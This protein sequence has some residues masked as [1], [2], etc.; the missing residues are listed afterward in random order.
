[1]CDSWR[2]LL[3]NILVA[4]A[5]A[6]GLAGIVVPVLPGVLLVLGAILAWAVVVGTSTGW[7]VFAVASVFLVI[8]S[9]VKFTVPGKRLK[10][11]GVPNSTLLVAALFG[12]V[13]FFVVPVLGFFVGFALGVYVAEAGRLGP[14][15]ARP[16]TVTALKA[17]GL[18][19]AIELF[20]ALLATLTWVVGVFIV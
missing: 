7:I 9:I 8:G 16:S 20:S 1:M 5:I 6:V 17:V 14:A 13:G 18:S 11:S 3:T 15:D 12:V 19:I 10:D 4:L 2:M